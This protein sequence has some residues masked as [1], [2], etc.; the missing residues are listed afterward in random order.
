MGRQYDDLTD[1]RFGRLLAV[2]YAGASHWHCKC[3]C[4]ARAVVLASNLKRGR[5]KSCGTCRQGATAEELRALKAQI[6]AENGERV[7]GRPAAMAALHMWRPT[8]M[9]IYYHRYKAPIGRN[10]VH[11]PY[12]SVAVW[13]DSDGRPLAATYPMH[14]RILR[15][16]RGDRRPSAE[17][18]ALT[19]LAAA[20]HM[21]ERAPAQ[22]WESWLAQC[23]VTVTTEQVGEGDTS[24][25]AT[26]ELMARLTAIGLWCASRD[27]FEARI[28][29]LPRVAPTPMAPTPDIYAHVAQRMEQ[30]APTTTYIEP[31]DDDVWGL[32]P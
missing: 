29:A 12:R 17:Q 30:P 27:E 8:R 1:R 31:D 25:T 2:S 19:M 28:K 18:I 6:N 22:P 21:P 5:T 3:D 11:L 16:T 10:T 23:N 24:V 26:S 7:R 14:T 9:T 4:G 13:M 32:T 15:I 20:G